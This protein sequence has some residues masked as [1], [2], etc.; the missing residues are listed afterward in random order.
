MAHP[1][2]RRLQAMYRALFEAYG[3]RNW[4]PGD[5][6]TEVMV[7]AVLTQNT[8][9]KNVE[10][11]IANLKG[12]GLIDI[13]RLARTPPEQLAEVIRPAGY[14]NVK[15]ARL[16]ALVRWIVERFG[17][18]PDRMFAEPTDRLREELLGVHGVGRETADS[19]LLYAGGHLSFVVDAYTYRVLRRHGFVDGSADYERMKELF[20]SNLPR[21]VALYNE[22]HALI[23]RVGHERC[24]P[25]DPRCDGC[26]LGRFKHD[27]EVEL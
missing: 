3:P 18:D 12:A 5:S 19:I 15:A 22:Y 7:G 1:T 6:P 13:K 21:D 27:V 4:W 8:N 23:V 20:E 11:A 14:Y 24:R 16:L 2:K 9:W 25:R 26:P 17:G 10:K